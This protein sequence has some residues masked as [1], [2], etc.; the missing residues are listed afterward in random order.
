VLSSHV[1]RY[2][3]VED[4]TGLESLVAQKDAKVEAGAEEQSS[5][6]KALLRTLRRRRL[7]HRC[8]DYSRSG[9]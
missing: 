6:K 4:R 1:M 7:L 2:K 3:D 5:L 9:K 8:K